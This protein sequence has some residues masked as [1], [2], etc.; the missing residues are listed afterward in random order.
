MPSMHVSVIKAACFSV[1]FA[2]AVLSVCAQSADEKSLDDIDVM[3]MDT[4]DVDE[5]V[6]KEEDALPAAVTVSVNGLSVPLAFSGHL[7]SEV[8]LGAIYE[9]GSTSSTTAFS[10]TNYLYMNARPDSTMSV[11][12]A[13][14]TAY[15]DFG[16]SLYEMYFTYVL[17][18]RVFITAGKKDTAWGYPRI[19][20]SFADSK[21]YLKKEETI[22]TEDTYT[23]ILYDS[24]SGVSGLVRIPFAFGTLTGVMLYH[25]TDSSPKQNDVS[26]AASLELIVFDTSINFFGRKYPSASGSMASYHQTPI[27]GVEIKR[28]LLGFDIYGQSMARISNYKKLR[29]EGTDAFDDSVQKII[30]TAGFYRLWDGFTPN[31]GAN[32]EYQDIYYPGAKEHSQRIGIDAGISKLGPAKNIKV[33]A[34]WRHSITDNNGYVK[35]AVSVS[36]ILPHATWDTGVKIDYGN[37]SSYK[38]PKYTFVT[39][40]SVSLDY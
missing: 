9:D 31:I 25:G 18:G 4:E 30:S 7:S 14:K 2:L 32:V 5:P 28:T 38:A 10:F 23:N 6:V 24:Q 3:F 33:G 36:G 20:T 22:V 13:I 12:G 17:F 16:V 1:L 11:H 21:S 26:V 27:A 35:P 29:D 37:S 15:P 34:L 19:F 8:G 39:A 40:I